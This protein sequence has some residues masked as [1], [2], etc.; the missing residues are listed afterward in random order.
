MNE[1]LP[2]EDELLKRLK[3]LPLPNED[4]AWE[5]MKRR[6]KRDD[7]EPVIPPVWKG[8]GIYGL[9][10][11]L[12]IAGLLIIDPAGWFHYKNNKEP[13]K[14]EGV[15]TMN[16]GDT[17]KVGRDE[18]LRLN[19]TAINL[20]NFNDTLLHQKSAAVLKPASGTA[21]GIPIPVNKNLS[22]RINHV[23][24][25]VQST[26]K[27]AVNRNS[28]LKVRQ[29]KIVKNNTPVSN[30]LKKTGGSMTASV[31]GAAADSL[32]NAQPTVRP[33][34]EQPSP[35]A[36]DSFPKIIS[37][38][39]AVHDTLTNENKDTLP[40]RK[41]T[42]DTPKANKI[43]YFSAGLGLHQLLPLAGQKANPY[44]SLGRKNSWGDYIPSIYLRMYK[45]KKWFVQSEFRYG[46]PQYTKEILFTQKKI[47]DS[48][49]S[50]ISITSNII[51]KTFYHQLPLSF[52]YF[53]LPGFSV[54]AG[55]TFNKFK[56]ALVQQDVHRTR[57]SGVDTQ[58][59]S[60]L[61]NWKKGDS[62]FVTTYIQGLTEL[63]YQWKRLS[64][65]AR[66]SF[67]LQPY[68]KFQ[69]PRGE[70]RKEKNTSLQLFIRY[71]LWR[72]VKK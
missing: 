33:I 21:A 70:Q 22:P 52:N 68:L 55:V 18:I 39:D 32:E 20:S 56:S 14:S 71:E 12:V 11:L 65:G 53:L 6:L 9:F 16:E 41:G 57:L 30:L 24:Q 60:G 17:R 31:S 62:N 5:D 58:K 42:V 13:V 44:N 8:C 61:V 23:F 40:S 3:E 43:L 64:A 37:K 36:G 59:T 50:S 46:A 4:G 27:K 34:P 66:Y 51:K 1:H 67:G 25:K 48:L 69:L 63:Q 10:L 54:G 72:S 47:T 2:Y 15:K 26:G 29:D 19:D 35:N 28:S 7:D 49:T 45:D 38:A